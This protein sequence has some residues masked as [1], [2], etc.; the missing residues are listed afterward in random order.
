[1]CLCS[2][3]ILLPHQQHRKYEDLEKKKSNFYF[4]RVNIVCYTFYR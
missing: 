2:F 3:I 1:M 4:Q